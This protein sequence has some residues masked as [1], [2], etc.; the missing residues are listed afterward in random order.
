MEIGLNSGN[1]GNSGRVPSDPVD[2]KGNKS[3]INTIPNMNNSNMVLDCQ[4][5][6]MLDCQTNLGL[7]LWIRSSVSFLL[8][9]SMKGLGRFGQCG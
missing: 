4:A 1:I 2:V 5:S 3:K 8:G 6:L 9:V 7:G